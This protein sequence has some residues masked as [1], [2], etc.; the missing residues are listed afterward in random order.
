MLYRGC[1]MFDQSWQRAIQAVKTVK[2]GSMR[3]NLRAKKL[4]EGIPEGINGDHR[5]LP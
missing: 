4:R 5:F 1:L 3:L 2:V